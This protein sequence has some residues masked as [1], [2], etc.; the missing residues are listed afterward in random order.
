M[1]FEKIKKYAPAVLRYGLALVFFWFAISQL[2][3]PAGWIGYL[4]PFLAGM[5]NAAMFIYANAVFEIIFASLLALGIFT[6]IA[7]LLLALHMIGIVV[8]LG[9]NAVAVR[10]FGLMIATFTVF[11]NGPDKLCL[12][13]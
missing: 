7:S 5:P 9:Y 13:K 4:P 3:N 2:T 12:K 10:D 6:R 8:S 1:N 11:L